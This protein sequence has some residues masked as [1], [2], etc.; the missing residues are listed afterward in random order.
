MRSAS[1]SFVTIHACDGQTDTDRIATE[2][3]CVAL[4]AVHGKNTATL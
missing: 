4:H 1:S 2:M 3:P